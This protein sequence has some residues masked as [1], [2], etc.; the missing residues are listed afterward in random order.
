MD[1][2]QQIVIVGAGAA[3]L[4]AAETLRKTGYK[5]SIYL[6]TQEKGMIVVM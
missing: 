5:G 1:K 4:S 6:L 3:G 2:N